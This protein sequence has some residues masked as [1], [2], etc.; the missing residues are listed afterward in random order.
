M[1][2]VSGKGSAYGRMCLSKDKGN[3]GRLRGSLGKELKGCEVRYEEVYNM[4]AVEVDC[5]L[6]KIKAVVV[7]NSSISVHSLS[8]LKER[9]SQRLG[10]VILGFALGLTVEYFA[11]GLSNGGT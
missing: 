1:E 4:R 9:S 3:E 6:E 8:Y 11:L 7:E 10:S 2:V 5:A